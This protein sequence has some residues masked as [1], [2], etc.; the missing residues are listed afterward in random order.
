MALTPKN[1]IE[2]WMKSLV[3][4]SLVSGL[5]P[6]NRREE[7]Y[8]EIIESKGSGNTYELP[9]ATNETLGGV[10]VG[11][12]LEVTEDGTLSVMEAPAPAPNV[13]HIGQEFPIGLMEINEELFTIYRKIVDF[14]ALPNATSKTVAHGIERDEIL[15]ILNYYGVASTSNHSSNLILPNS[16]TETPEVNNVYLAV[17]GSK[18]TITTGKDRS[19]VSAL[20]TIEYVKVNV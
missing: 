15:H 10:I 20:V 6:K 12:G 4:G 11:N 8:K 7:W 16:A 18:I 14:G 2:K 13:Q 1:R 5:S 9:P 17:G 19:N 3:D